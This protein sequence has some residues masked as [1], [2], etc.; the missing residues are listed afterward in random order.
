MA[1]LRERT[2]EAVFQS[3]HP[4]RGA[5]HDGN[6]KDI[7]FSISIHAPRE[8]CD[9]DGNAK[10]IRFSISIHAPREGCDLLTP[11]I[12]PAVT[13]F[14]ST[15]PVRGA[16]FIVTVGGVCLIISIHAPRE[17]CDT[18]SALVDHQ[19]PNFNPRTP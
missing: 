11:P 1:E 8:G 7:R 19:F 2:A 9:H 13:I 6:A 5:T 4:V 18:R 10:G 3:T 16:T 12:L 15:H 17:G 14:Q